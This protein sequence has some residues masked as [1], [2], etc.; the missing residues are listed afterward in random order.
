MTEQTLRER[1]AFFSITARF[2]RGPKDLYIRPALAVRVVQDWL[3]DQPERMPTDGFGDEDTY[4]NGWNDCLK[5]LA[6]ALGD[7][8]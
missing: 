3:L 1:L 8:P 6:Q 4:N 7:T 2:Q 5:A